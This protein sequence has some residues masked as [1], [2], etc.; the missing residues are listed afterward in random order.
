MKTGVLWGEVFGW[1]YRVCGTGRL[2]I[3]YVYDIELDLSILGTDAPLARDDSV[4]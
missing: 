4:F 3:T 1:Q 2:H